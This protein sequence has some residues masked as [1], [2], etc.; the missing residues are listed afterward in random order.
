MEALGQAGTCLSA[1]GLG[2]HLFGSY[3]PICLFL[4]TSPF[5]SALSFVT[6]M[7]C[8]PPG[9]FASRATY[10][11][12]QDWAVP[13]QCFYSTAL[14]PWSSSEEAERVKMSSCT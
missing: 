10:P 12:A 5:P 2:V 9:S 1:S 11:W 7:T 13:P 6:L 4:P 8:L 3:R 14:S